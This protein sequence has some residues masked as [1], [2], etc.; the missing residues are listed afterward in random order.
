[1]I[2]NQ[3][4]GVAVETYLPN[5]I[6]FISKDEISTSNVAN[7]DIVV[8]LYLKRKEKILLG[9]VEEFINKVDT[10][11]HQPHCININFQNDRP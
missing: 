7:K 4:S 6:P 2:S 5:H 8:T 9:Y 10:V 3:L 1:M 11:R